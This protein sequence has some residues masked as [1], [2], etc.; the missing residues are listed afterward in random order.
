ME[1]HPLA[2]HEVMFI[3]A[4]VSQASKEQQEK[5]LGRARRR[6]IIGCYAQTEMGHGEKLFLYKSRYPTSN[7]D[8]K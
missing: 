1:G 3:P 6:E 4:L 7:Y 8:S 2:L 5:W